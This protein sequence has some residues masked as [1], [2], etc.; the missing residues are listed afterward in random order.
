LRQATTVI[1]DRR[2][3]DDLDLPADWH[4]SSPIHP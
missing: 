4:R 3:F 1:A 2:A